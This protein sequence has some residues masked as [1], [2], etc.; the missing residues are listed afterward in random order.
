[1]GKRLTGYLNWTRGRKQHHQMAALEVILA[2]IAA[3]SPDCIAL[4]GDLVNIALP[5]EFDTAQ[6]FLSRLGPPDRVMLVPGNHDIYVASARRH[7]TRAF[8]RYIAG[9]HEPPPRR[10]DYAFPAVRRIGGVALVGVNTGVPKPP[11]MA[12][13]TLGRAQIE[14]LGDT[15][16]ALKAEGL[17]R[18]LLIH[19]PPFPI[20]PMK[21]LTDQA[22]LAALLRRVGCDLILHGHTHKGTTHMLEGPAGPIPVLGVASASASTDGTAEPAAWTLIDIQ[23]TPGNGGI[24]VRRRTLS[25]DNAAIP[26]ASMDFTL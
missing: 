24:A 7:A 5:G 4:T 6:A 17:V 20:A 2:D 22:A 10:L 16:T 26:L 13:G 9:D 23:G 11:F 25:S 19:H 8:G 3:H 1:M 12:T 21:R 18:V 14:A 15:L